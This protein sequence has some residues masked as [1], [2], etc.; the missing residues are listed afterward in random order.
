MHERIRGGSPS[1]LMKAAQ[2]CMKLKKINLSGK[3]TLIVILFIYILPT[4][5]L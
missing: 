3:I 4:G 5:L 1:I 2:L